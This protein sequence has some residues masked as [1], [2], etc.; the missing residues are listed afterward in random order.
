VRRLLVVV[1]LLGATSAYAEDGKSV[2]VELNGKCQ[3]TDSFTHQL[4][5]LMGFSSSSSINCQSVRTDWNSRIEFIKDPKSAE[6]ILIFTGKPGP[7]QYSLDISG[8]IQF[9]LDLQ[10]ATGRCQMFRSDDSAGKRSIFCF[11]EAKDGLGERQATMVQFTVEEEVLV[12]GETKKIYG[13]C[14]SSKVSEI[15][16]NEE[17]ARV[18]ESYRPI[19]FLSTPSCE[20]A[21]I[22]GG[23]RVMFTNKIGATDRLVFSGASQNGDPNR[24]VVKTITIGNLKPK[25]AI[26]GS[27]VGIRELDGTL[28]TLCS[29]AF[30]EAG[31]VKAVTV[32]F[33]KPLPI[34]D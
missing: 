21:T 8:I 22:K 29:A 24:M 12:I 23:N 14:S 1:L 27:C 33:P 17:V 19:E 26:A 31:R 5:R 9:G 4:T 15:V 16:L 30:E 10:P 13:A 11:A 25:K 2:T 6:P 3:H 7:D 34:E 18:Y 20:G 32:E 28:Y